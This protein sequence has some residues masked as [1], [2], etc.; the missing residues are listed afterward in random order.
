MPK[1]PPLE[2]EKEILVLREKQ[3]KKKIFEETI[4]TQVGTKLAMDEE[5]TDILEMEGLKN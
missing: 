1:F 4:K 2:G 3:L 5:K